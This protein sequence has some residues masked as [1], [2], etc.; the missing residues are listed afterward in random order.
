MQI[1]VF[2]LG[3]EEFAV[4]TSK[5][6]NINHVMKVT[7]VLKAAPHIKG[8]INLRGNIISLIDVNLLLNINSDKEEQ[9]NI[10]IIDIENNS[11][12]IIEKRF[13]IDGKPGYYL[14][15]Q[16]I[17][18][19]PKLSDK[20][21]MSIVNKVV[22]KV[23]SEYAVFEGDPLP[24]VKKQLAQL[25]ME[26]RPIKPME[27]AKKVVESDYNATQEVETIMRDLGIEED[28]EIVNVP[29]SVD[30]M[31]RCKLVLDDDRVIELSVDDY[32]EGVD[33]S[34][35]MDERGLTRIILKNIKDVVVK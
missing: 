6:Q 32:L 34:R 10:I 30:R 22:K 27:L 35:E 24:V 28:D 11:L 33:I 15:E 20:Q 18:G 9:E 13:M 31:S 7:R 23:D 12:S 4:E 26:H 29:V 17:K 2:R 8:L 1:V 14:N 3:E 5:V 19:E 16:Y 21:K 25:V